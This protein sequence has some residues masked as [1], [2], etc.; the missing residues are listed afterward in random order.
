LDLTLS[1]G[2]VF[3]A[4]ELALSLEKLTNEKLLNLHGVSALDNI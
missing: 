2:H 4:M 3:S 1:F